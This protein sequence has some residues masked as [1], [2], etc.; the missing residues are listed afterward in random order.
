VSAPHGGEGRGKEGQ[1]LRR[2]GGRTPAAVQSVAPAK[3]MKA[4]VCGNVS[5]GGVAATDGVGATP[6]AAVART[7]PCAVVI[8]RSS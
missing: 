8:R 4:G 6:I 3:G 2:R 1:A 7:V 5:A